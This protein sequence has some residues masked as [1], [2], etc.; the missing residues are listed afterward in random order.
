MAGR[1]VDS[2]EALLRLVRII[3]ILYQSTHTPNPK[4]LDRLRKIE[5]GSRKQ[6]RDRS[7]RLV[8]RFLALA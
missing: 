2:D 7:I 5:E 1:S 6:D 8:Q 3:R 4:E